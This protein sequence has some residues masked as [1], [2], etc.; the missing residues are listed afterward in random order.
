MRFS[1]FFEMQISEPTR[2]AEHRLFHD[3][4]E[5]AVLADALG[6]HGVWA[7]E[8][9]GLYEYAHSSAP[10]IFLAHLSG[11]TSRI[12]LGHGVTLTPHRYNHPIRIAER[13]AA[14]D[15]LS[16]GRVDW[17][18]GKSGSRVE[19]DAFGNDPAVL[20]DQWLEALRMVPRM[21]QQDVFEWHSELYDIPPT[22]VVPTP[23]QQPHP[24]MFA[25]CTNPKTAELAGSLGLGA[26]N[27]AAGTDD[28]LA[29][30]VR[31]Y[32]ERQAVA[33]PDG[34]Q[35]TNR[36]VCTP[37]ALVLEDDHL[38]A[39]HGYRGSR[40]FWEAMQQYY[41][42]RDRPVG[43][44]PIG[45]DD[46]PETDLAELMDR[47]S[48]HNSPL[49]AVIGDPVSARETVSRFAAAGV[50]ELALVMQ[51]GTVPHELIMTSIRLF[52]EKVMPDFAD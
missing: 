19:Q 28:E 24:P 11:R 1:L 39:R 32:R 46:L 4:V 12:R 35:P 48:R 17:G 27:F 15:I 30:K 40:F 51:V 45:R 20:Q 44:L 5:Q 2:A 33:T 50:D 25:A 13:V 23:V 52:A 22:Q 49:T 21:W 6:Y 14:L 16:G 8:H 37:T 42:Y 34:Y 36:Y 31:V 3:S 10:E 41:A 7:A 9:H 38:A 29:A 43:R 47:R 26:L 18:S